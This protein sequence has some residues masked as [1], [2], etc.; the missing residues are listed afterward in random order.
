MSSSLSSSIRGPKDV[1]RQ[2]SDREL[3]A[4]DLMLRTLRSVAPE[5]RSRL[6]RLLTEYFDG[7]SRADSGREPIVGD[8]RDFL[9]IAQPKTPMERVLC[10]AYYLASNGIAREFSALDINR[11]N[12]DARQIKIQGVPEILEDAAANGLMKVRG[13]RYALTQKGRLAVTELL[14]RRDSSRSALRTKP[15]QRKR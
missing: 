15:R 10:L 3:G 8:L 4:L 9:L 14:R 5:D 2:V 11:T 1:A 13:R 6:L 7:S 12:T